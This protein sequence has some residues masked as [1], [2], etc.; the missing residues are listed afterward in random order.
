MATEGDIELN[1]SLAVFIQVDVRDG[2]LGG[3]LDDERLG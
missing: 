2:T 1:S 3:A